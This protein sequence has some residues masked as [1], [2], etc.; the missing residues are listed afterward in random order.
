MNNTNTTKEL[1][2]IMLHIKCETLEIF[3]D[4]I[5]KFIKNCNLYE[6]IVILNYMVSQDLVDTISNSIFKVLSSQLDKMIML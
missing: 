5:I 3:D 1:D 4:T 2:K 6:S